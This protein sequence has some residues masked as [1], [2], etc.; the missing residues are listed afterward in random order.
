MM[1]HMEEKVEKNIE[2]LMAGLEKRGDV[3]GFMQKVDDKLSDLRCENV[4][5]RAS[6]RQE[7]AQMKVQMRSD[8]SKD[9]NQR[10]TS[11]ACSGWTP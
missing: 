10:V 1:S 3:D 11:T 4:S 6:S 2:M 7:L 9:F 8:L 5:E